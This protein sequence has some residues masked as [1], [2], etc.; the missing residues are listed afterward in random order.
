MNAADMSVSKNGQRVGFAA[1]LA[2]IAAR[3]GEDSPQ[4]ENSA[5][6]IDAVSDELKRRGLATSLLG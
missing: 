1:C 6:V 5:R 2:D 3:Y 4:Y